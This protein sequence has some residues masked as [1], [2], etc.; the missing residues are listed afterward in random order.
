LTAQPSGTIDGPQN[1]TSAQK[2]IDDLAFEGLC[3]DSM[4]TPDP[5]SEYGQ[6]WKRDLTR[7]CYKGHG[8][9]CSLDVY[10]NV[11]KAQM[12]LPVTQDDFY[13]EDYIAA[14]YLWGKTWS[15]GLFPNYAD[16][17]GSN[18]EIFFRCAQIVREA[19]ELLGGEVMTLDNFEVPLTIKTPVMLTA[20]MTE[21]GFQHIDTENLVAWRYL[22]D[23][24]MDKFNC[25]NT[26][27]GAIK[28][29]TSSYCNQLDISYSDFAENG[30]LQKARSLKKEWPETFRAF[31][32][33]LPT[34]DG[35]GTYALDNIQCIKY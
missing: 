11:G 29:I 2:I 26:A 4:D 5:S 8:Q 27:C 14:A 32:L 22:S 10:A 34:S 19:S 28:I 17:D 35:V 12:A 31:T 7:G 3:D 6:Y 30:D 1:Y 18:Y 9:E 20:S 13:G 15:V 25:G 21:Q 33:K 23:T 16:M 24:E